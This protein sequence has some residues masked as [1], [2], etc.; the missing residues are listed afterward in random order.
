MWNLNA[1]RSE[2]QKKGHYQFS[3]NVTRFPEAVTLFLENVTDL[4]KDKLHDKKVLGILIGDPV[5]RKRDSVS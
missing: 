4:P 5:I 1:E 3:I 2:I